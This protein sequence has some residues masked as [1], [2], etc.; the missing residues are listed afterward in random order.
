MGE[1]RKDA[2]RIGFDR[3]V[4][5]EFRAA[6]VTSDAGLLALRELDDALGLTV[7][8]GQ[9]LLAITMSSTRR[10]VGPGLA[11]SWPR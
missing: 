10:P 8:A 4:E 1:E 5:L 3:S 6:H 11:A 9:V 2:F 7:L